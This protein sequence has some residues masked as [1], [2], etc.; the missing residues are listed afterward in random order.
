MEENEYH[1][2]SVYPESEGEEI[3]GTAAPHSVEFWKSIDPE[4][5]PPYVHGFVPSLKQW[6]RFYVDQIGEPRWDPSRFQDLILPDVPKEVIRSL[7]NAHQYPEEGVRD[8]QEL[9]GKGLVV[10]LHGTP[11]T[12]TI[13]TL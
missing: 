8:Q 7:V 12:G 10:L 5:C 6:S 4:L 11:G 9:K 3:L 13:Q 1:Q 2:E